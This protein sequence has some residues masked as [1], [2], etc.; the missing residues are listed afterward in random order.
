MPERVNMTF[1]SYEEEHRWNSIVKA[2]KVWNDE[3]L[4]VP[5]SRRPPAYLVAFLA[6][7]KRVS[8]NEVMEAWKAAKSKEENDA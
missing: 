4:V 6:G 2:I 7:L 5:F 3:V 8:K 1:L